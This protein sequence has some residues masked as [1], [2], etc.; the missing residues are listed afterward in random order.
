MDG[1]VYI[2]KRQLK[3]SKKHPQG[4]TRY[5]VTSVVDNRKASHGGFERLSDAKARKR[6]LETQIASASFGAR[7]V[8]ATLFSDFYQTWW[9]SKQKSLS[10]SAA[11]QYES[12]MRLY[13]LPFFGRFRMADIRPMD[14]QQFIRGLDGLSP[15]YVETIYRHLCVAMRTAADLEFI[16][17]SPC[18]GIDLPRKS[19]STESRLEPDDFWA[20][21]DNLHFPYKAMFALCGFGGLRIGEVM[22][23]SW[24]HVDFD[25]KA[26][27]IERAW[28]IT[29]CEFHAPKTVSSRRIVDMLSPVAE[30]LREYQ[31]EEPGAGPDDLLFPSPEDASRPL[32][33][34]TVYGV[35][36]RGLE[37]AGLPKVT[38]HSLRHFYA[39]VLLQ[40]GVS[41]ATLSRNLGHSS[42]A[43]T[44]SIYAHEMKTGLGE[45][46]ERAEG[47][48]RPSVEE[49]ENNGP[50]E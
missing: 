36:V 16:D 3:P 47:L 22:G 46:L 13:I 30:I 10:D 17:R 39:S 1:Y 20:L 19:K 18:R 15:G 25:R 37:F 23:L 24:R 35:F 29:I 26:I 8:G 5:Y 41:V 33:Y 42:P 6:V 14:V 7:D 11:R 49:D 40:A 2:E 28:G 48:F 32:S 38:I 12:S 4:R 43:I 50:N 27:H 21:L 9:S 44:M 45:G 31:T 34:Q